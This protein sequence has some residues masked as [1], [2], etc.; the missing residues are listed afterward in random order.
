MAYIPEDPMPSG[1]IEENQLQKFHRGERRYQIER[2][3][4]K[5]QYYWGYG[6]SFTLYTRYSELIPPGI[7]E[8]TPTQQSRVVQNPQCCSCLGCSRS[9]KYLG[10]TLKELSWYLLANKEMEDLD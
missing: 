1:I 3:K 2:L 6:T 8:M 4:K 7:R 10:R 5:R 9:R